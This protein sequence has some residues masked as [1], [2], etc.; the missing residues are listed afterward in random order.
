VLGTFFAPV[1]IFDKFKF[2]RSVGFVFFREIILG[3]ADGTAE[4]D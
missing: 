1:A 2:V 3:T 4:G